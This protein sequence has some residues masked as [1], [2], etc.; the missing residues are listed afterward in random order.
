MRSSSLRSRQRRTPPAVPPNVI[1]HVTTPTSRIDTYFSRLA[2]AASACTLVLAVF[3]YFYTVLPVF[4]NQKLQEDN[5]KLEL[6]SARE[7]KALAELQ[8]RQSRVQNEIKKLNLELMH[9]Q[10]ATQASDQRAKAAEGREIVAK[11]RAMVAE[12]REGEARLSAEIAQS[13]L[14]MELENLDAARR[15][16]LI[17]DFRQ[18]V[19][20]VQLRN[21]WEFMNEIYKHGEDGDQ[22]KNGEFIVAVKEKFISPAKLLDTAL[23]NFSDTLE[24]SKVPNHYLSDLEK[25]V[26]QE[27]SVT[28]DV[29]DVEKLRKEY[30]EKASLLSDLSTADARA[31]LEKQRLSAEKAGKR[32][33]VKDG[34]L[35]RL[36]RGFQIGRR[37]SL[38]SEY[39]EIL[40][41]ANN[42]CSKL[43]DQAV[44]RI[45][46]RFDPK[47]VHPE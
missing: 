28:C 23:K 21:H 32:L 5:A 45:S 46:K 24:R 40:S 38:D 43:L 26:A 12:E 41:N 22:R 34:D 29:P 33:W 18:N 27:T 17:R 42:M 30:I 7:K 9:M 36:A 13:N 1:V 6:D 16:I 25:I 35:Q 14:R 19:S 3:G 11:N 31:E 44:D 39:R 8:T 47:S 4:Q 15:T 20:F 2:H 37:F 10:E